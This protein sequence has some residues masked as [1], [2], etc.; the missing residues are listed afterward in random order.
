[1]G[2]AVCLFVCLS[3][4]C[5]RYSGTGSGENMER[6]CVKEGEGEG[7]LGSERRGGVELERVDDK[8]NT[9]NIV[10]RWKVVKDTVRYV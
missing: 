1:M 7:E 3:E 6:V 5:Q 2:E 8:H 10:E 4:R 9:K